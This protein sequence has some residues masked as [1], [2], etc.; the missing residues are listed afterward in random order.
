MYISL[1]ASRYPHPSVNKRPPVLVPT[2]TT[3]HLYIP[4]PPTSQTK[5]K[6][7]STSRRPLHR[8][9][10]DLAPTLVTDPLPRAL[11]PHQR[12]VEAVGAEILPEAD[13]LLVDGVLADVGQEEPGE[14]AGEDGEA[15]GDPER[16]LA[17]AG[18]VGGVVLDDGEDPGADE[19]ADLAD[20]GGDAVVLAADGRYFLFLS[21]L[22]PTKKKKKPKRV[23][24]SY[25]ILVALV[26]LAIRPMLSPGPISPSDRKMP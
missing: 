23:E 15:G 24:R 1:L 22:Q 16:I 21:S 18:G 5:P 9:G 10:S 12:G 4:P 26:L 6:P 3:T 2:F 11:Q 17:L 13:V 19:G 25:R 14:G 8:L 20:G 7:P